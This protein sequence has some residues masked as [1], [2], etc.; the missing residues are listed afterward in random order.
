MKSHSKQGTPKAS[1]G[2]QAKVSETRR[3]ES[4][5]LPLRTSARHSGVTA[6]EPDITPKSKKETPCSKKEVTE[7]KP[8]KSIE[9]SLPEP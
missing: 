8:E 5:A 6:P 7:K 3:K 1:Q 4:S 2:L 9:D